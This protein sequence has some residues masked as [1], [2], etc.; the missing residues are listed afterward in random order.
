MSAEAYPLRVETVL[1]A[2]FSEWRSGDAL[3][4]R[5][6]ENWQLVYV[7]DGTVE[8]GCDSRRVTLR[9]GGVLFHQPN[10][11]HRMRVV[12]DLPPEVLRIEFRCDGTEMDRFRGRVF[13]AEPSELVL[14]NTLCRTTA[15]V[16]VQQERPWTVPA[17]REDA[18][19]GAQQQYLLYLEHLLILLGRRVGRA[20][21]PSARVLRDRQYASLIAVARTY[22]AEHLDREVRLDELCRA[23]GC[24]PRALQQAFRARTRHGPM[25]EHAQMKLDYAK[26]LLARGSTPGEV[27]S[28]LG[29]CSG[30]YFSRKFKEATGST[31]SAYRLAQQNLTHRPHPPPPAADTAPAPGPDATKTHTTR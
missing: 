26:Q 16:F 14:L 8:E 18:P 23:C 28:R 22:L 30:A 29:Y 6:P 13:H 20:R 9:Q 3:P 2:S 7:R 19:F 25:E 17:R 4:E 12:G 15:N 5:C 24:T 21:Q 31:P 27:A 10:E 1:A 11:K